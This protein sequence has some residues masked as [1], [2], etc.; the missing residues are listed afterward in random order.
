MAAKSDPVGRLDR[1]HLHVRDVDTAQ[2]AGELL[3]LLIADLGLQSL[4]KPVAN[5]LDERLLSRALG[6]A[7]YQ[8]ALDVTAAI[9]ELRRG[10]GSQWDPSL[11]ERFV[12]TIAATE[13]SVINETAP[14]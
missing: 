6:D 2:P 4:G 5:G 9:L 7:P 11:V 8:K 12:K 3:G 10:A 1:L 14:H 13:T